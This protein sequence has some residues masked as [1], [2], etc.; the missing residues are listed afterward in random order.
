MTVG[1]LAPGSYALMHDYTRDARD[2]LHTAYAFDFLGA[3]PGVEK[4]ARDLS[5][6]GAKGRT[7]AGRAGRFRT[8]T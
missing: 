5:G 7:M 6:S 1:E 8:M 4:A 3:W 2:G